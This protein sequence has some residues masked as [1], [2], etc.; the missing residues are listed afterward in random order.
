[1]LAL[2]VRGQT[3]LLSHLV[4]YATHTGQREVGTSGAVRDPEPLFAEFR[5]V[6]L[7]FADGSAVTLDGPQTEAFFAFLGRHARTLNLDHVEEQTLGHVVVHGTDE[8][9]DVVL[10]QPPSTPDDNL[11]PAIP[12]GFFR[13][14]D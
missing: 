6:E 11:P 8:G 10:D 2:T 13:P 14:R 12:P 4:R 1:M 3:Y 5:F 9:G 7:H